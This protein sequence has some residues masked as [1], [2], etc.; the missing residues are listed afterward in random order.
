MKYLWQ[1]ETGFLKDIVEQY[2]EPR[3]AY[4]TISTLLGRMCDKNYVGFTKFGRD[5]RYYPV[6]KKNEYF[7]SQLKTMI[8]HFFNDSP[9][10]FASFFTKSTDMSVEE[11]NE[12]REMVNKKLMEKKTE[13]K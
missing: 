1:L 2:P 13:G 10:Q 8:A 4:T 12:L 11:L 3:P 9:S 7:T 5:K 6:L